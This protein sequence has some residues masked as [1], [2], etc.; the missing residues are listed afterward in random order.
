MRFHW[1]PLRPGELD[2]ELVW[3][4]VTIASAGL[5]AVWLSLQLPT[6]QCTFRSLTGYPCVTCG[7]T[8]GVMALLQGNVF[9][10][11]RLNPL[12]AVGLSAVAVF[13]LY[14]LAVLLTGARRLRVSF[15]ARAWKTSLAIGGTA[16]LLNWIYLL[17]L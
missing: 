2:T 17:R 16:V 7:A 11:W 10:A 13:N 6:P 1:R 4:C 3:L 9:A 5:A 15:T 14:A 8:R 12:V